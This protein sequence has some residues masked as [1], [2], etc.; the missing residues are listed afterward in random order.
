MQVTARY[1][2]WKEANVTKDS[3][4]TAKALPN[5]VQ[6][7]RCNVG[8]YMSRATER[9]CLLPQARQPNHSEVILGAAGV[10]SDTVGAAS[11]LGMKLRVKFT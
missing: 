6:S 10:N 4:I 8:I 5:L 1:A 9:T 2:S 7:T 3:I 11:I